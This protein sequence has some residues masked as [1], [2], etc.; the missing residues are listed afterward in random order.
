MVFLSIGILI[1][2]LATGILGEG[3]KT[4]PAYLP[5]FNASL[6]ILI[7][8][9]LGLSAIIFTG[10]LQVKKNINKNVNTKARI[11]ELE[12]ERDALLAKK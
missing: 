2:S 6:I 1:F 8:A 7:I 5:S 10:V 11:E 3:S 4:D 9:I 12:T